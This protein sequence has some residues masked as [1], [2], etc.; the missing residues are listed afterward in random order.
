MISAA[1]VIKPSALSSTT[2]SHTENAYLFFSIVYLIL[3][4]IYFVIH[5][6]GLNEK[7]FLER[8]PFPLIVKASMLS[9]FYLL[10]S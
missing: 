5:M 8:I 6:T 9:D 10:I 7:G 2:R 3:E 4:V 1:A